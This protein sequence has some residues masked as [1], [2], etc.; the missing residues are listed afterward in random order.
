MDLGHYLNMQ[1]VQCNATHVDAP[2]K[3]GDVRTTKQGFAK[4]GYTASV[5]QDTCSKLLLLFIYSRQGKTWLMNPPIIVQL[6]SIIA[7]LLVG[8]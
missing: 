3:H 6:I 7:V 8:T 4:K 1:G 5:I 2:A